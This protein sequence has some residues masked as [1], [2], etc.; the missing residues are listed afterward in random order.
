[1]TVSGTAVSMFEVKCC[2][3]PVLFDGCRSLPSVT[4]MGTIVEVG[5]SNNT[6]ST[7][8]FRS[9][10]FDSSCQVY[11][12]QTTSFYIMVIRVNEIRFDLK[13]NSCYPN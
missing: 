2:F 5:Y 4:G 6:F 11:N 7:S 10:V 13:N 1:M 8:G 12:A 3:P 9:V